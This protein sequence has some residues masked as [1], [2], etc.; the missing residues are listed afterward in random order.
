M[1]KKFHTHML[2]RVR[3]D[4]LSN[5]QALAEAYGLSLSDWVRNNLDLEVLSMR[6]RIA[7]ILAERDNSSQYRKI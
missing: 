4:Q 5:Y 7:K 3:H 2:I 6:H 1:K